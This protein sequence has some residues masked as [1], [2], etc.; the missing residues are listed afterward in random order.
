MT[1]VQAQGAMGVGWGAASS[2][3]PDA[4]QVAREQAQRLYHQQM[5]Q[6]Q[7][8]PQQ[9]QQQQ[10]QPHMRASSGVPLDLGALNGHFCIHLHK[11]SAYCIMTH[12]TCMTCNNNDRIT[13]NM[14][15]VFWYI[16]CTAVCEESEIVTLHAEF[17]RRF[18]SSCAMRWQHSHVC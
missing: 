7:R 1:H 8:H 13:V 4:G 17:E 3:W 11:S 6:S 9:Q 5:Q 18:L 2:Q 15:H 16:T 12:G 14:Y 10:Q